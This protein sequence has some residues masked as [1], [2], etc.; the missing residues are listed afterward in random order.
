MSLRAIAWQSRGY[1]DQPIAYSFHIL[2]E[3][4]ED[5]AEVSAWINANAL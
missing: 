3:A 4:I 1:T 2:N 5:C